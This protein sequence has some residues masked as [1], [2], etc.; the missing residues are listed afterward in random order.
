MWK[1]SEQLPVATSLS[2]KLKA[3]SAETVLHLYTLISFM[4]NGQ[5]SRYYDYKSWDIK[6]CDKQRCTFISITFPQYHKV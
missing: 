2:K 5:F 1:G 4:L 6:V 3:A